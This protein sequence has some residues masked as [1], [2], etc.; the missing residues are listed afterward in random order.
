MKTTIE[1]TISNLGKNEGTL[2]WLLEQPIKI[3]IGKSKDGKTCAWLA[4]GDKSEN[5]ACYGYHIT[6][7]ECPYPGEI[8]D[9][10]IDRVD[11]QLAPAFGVVMTDPAWGKVKELIELA[12][13]QFRQAVS[14]LEAAEVEV[15]SKVEF[16][17]SK[18]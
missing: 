1:I 10:E 14:D 9:T 4:I 7:Y 8:R 18:N 17:V 3:T 16:S 6:D 5:V 12:R 15:A 11:E 2:G 13:K